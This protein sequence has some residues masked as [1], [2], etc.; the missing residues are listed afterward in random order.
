MKKNPIFLAMLVVMLASS[1]VFIGCPDGDENKKKFVAVT[2]ITG[3]PTTATVGVAFTLAGT[4]EPK[5]ATNKDI[6]WYSID[7]RANILAD[8]TP[9]L[10]KTWKMRA[11]IKDG[12]AKDKDFTKEFDLVVGPGAPASDW[13]T[14][15]TTR[16]SATSLTAAK[17]QYEIKSGYGATD[18]I[19][20]WYS[21]TV[22]KDQT[23]WIW[24]DDA[25]A[26]VDTDKGEDIKVS[27]YYADGKVIFSEIDNGW[28][29]TVYFKA[30]EAGTVYLFVEDKF[31]SN[32]SGFG[33][34]DYSICF[35]TLATKPSGWA[36]P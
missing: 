10:V 8:Q 18:P 11:T 26:Y 6:T 21:F 30:S 7:D 2:D 9:N 28:G 17:W 23:Y 24:W 35:N 3:V 20:D 14:K 5:N 12:V 15:A 27:G 29:N 1:L 16:N 25:W 22:T 32:I 4:V 33:T 31:F 34:R 36:A 13:A 19:A